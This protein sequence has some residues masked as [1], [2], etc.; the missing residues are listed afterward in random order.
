MSGLLSRLMPKQ[1]NFFELFIALADNLHRAAEVLVEMFQK[2]DNP[3]K[4]AERI[5]D[6]EHVGDKLTRALFTRLNKSFITPFDREDIQSLSSHIDDVLD[7]IDAASSDMITYKIPRVRPG[8]AEMT[9][10]LSAATY[11]VALVVRA[12]GK[13]DGVLEKC[14]EINRLEHESDRLS[15]LLIAQLFDEER[16]P[17]QIIKWK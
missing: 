5:M 6:L 15:G 17:I 1:E 9:Q 12:L 11:Q 13:H 14:T 8:V 7:L 16:D 3:E 10:V 4:S 2:Y